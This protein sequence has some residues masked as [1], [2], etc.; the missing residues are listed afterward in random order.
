[1]H[2]VSFETICLKNPFQ[3]HCCPHND[4]KSMVKHF[5][6]LHR[7]SVIW[8]FDR[9]CLGPGTYQDAPINR[10]KKGTPPSYSMGMKW[11]EFTL[12]PTP[13]SNAYDVAP[14]RRRTKKEVQ[15]NHVG[16]Y[17]WKGL[18]LTIFHLLLQTLTTSHQE[19]EGPRKRYKMIIQGVMYETGKKEFWCFN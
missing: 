3:L 13:A 9:H 18:G 14:G 8:S 15:D 12:R 10:Y 4:A 7:F 6:F 17:V 11:T 19:E 5:I 16:C 2:Q 1:M